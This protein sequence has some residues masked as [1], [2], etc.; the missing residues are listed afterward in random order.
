MKNNERL[1]D[2]ITDIDDDL[3]DDA[4]K[5]RRKKPPKSFWYELIAAC[6]VIAIGVGALV[7]RKPAEDEILS[8]GMANNDPLESN[9][10]VDASPSETQ[11]STSATSGA[12]NTYAIALPEY[13]AM[14]QYPADPNHDWDAYDA[15]ETA[16]RERVGL[17]YRSDGLERFVTESI[18]EFL[19]GVDGEN[20]VY[21]PLNVY[22]ALAMLAE[23]SDGSS[24][25]Q[26]LDVL[27]C[28]SIE[29]LRTQA[30]NL[31][32]ANYC[33]D[34][35]V[36]SL[37][38]SSL[39]LSDSVTFKQETLD[40]LSNT[41]YASAFRG[42]MGTAAFDQALQDW[43]NAQTGGLLAEQVG[44]LTMDEDTVLSLVTT[45]YYCAKWTAEF[46]ETATTQSTFHGANGDALCD[47]MNGSSWDYYY[48]G[49]NFAAVRQDLA[50]CGSM[51]FI[52]PDEE[53]DV[54]A[55][56]TDAEV[57]D[58]MLCNG[59]WEKRSYLWIDLSVPKFD[60]SSQLS[61]SESLQALGIT[62]VFDV[63]TSDFTP[64]TDDTPLFVS[65]VLHGARVTIDE[66]GIEAA[67]YTQ[68]YL[69]GDMPPEGTVTFVLD[70]PFLFVITNE[71]GLPLFVGTVQQPG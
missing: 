4:G 11:I 19:T 37:L 2:A 12:Y 8:T 35:T 51:W 60:V 10:M 53:V 31:W 45:I 52:L 63:E 3:V 15:W 34:G 9:D 26:I 57:M 61:L 33:D 25:Q 16:Y 56:L 17:Q 68:I 14:T 50:N 5:R 66:K 48:W 28:D 70:R 27:G 36:T 29:S 58:F 42:T 6:L 22:M 62:E 13:P 69:Y 43:L 20:R 21:S 41:Y 24:R 47:F 30:G 64:T 55:L 54:E 65:E 18:Q 40:L 59:S 67:A 7:V 71:Q 1:Y 38:A 49:E 32:N 46:S 23:L 44:G 39:W